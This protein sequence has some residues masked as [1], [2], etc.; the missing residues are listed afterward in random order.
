MFIRIKS[1]TAD[2][3]YKSASITSFTV[4][5]QSAVTKRWYITIVMGKTERKFAWATETEMRAYEK[6]L[7]NVLEVKEI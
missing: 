3:R 7:D 1:L 4:D 6:Y 5:G 2:A